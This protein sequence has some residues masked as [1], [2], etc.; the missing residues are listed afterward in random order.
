MSIPKGFSSWSAVLPKKGLADKSLTPTLSTAESLPNAAAVL[1]K[2]SADAVRAELQVLLAEIKRLSIQQERLKAEV[3]GM[4]TWKAKDAAANYNPNKNKS[5]P[6]LGGFTMAE[7]LGPALTLPVGRQNTASSSDWSEAAVETPIRN[8]VSGGYTSFTV[9]RDLL[10]MDL[11]PAN[12]DSDHGSATGE[13]QAPAALALPAG[14]TPDQL[15]RARKHR[16]KY[17]L[18]L[19]RPNSPKPKK[20]SSQKNSRLGI[21]ISRAREILGMTT[22]HTAEAQKRSLQKL[23]TQK[24]HSF[25]GGVPPDR[26][27]DIFADASPAGKQYVARRF[28]D[29]ISRHESPKQATEKLARQPV[30]VSAAV[31]T[32][33]A[34]PGRPCASSG[35]H[36]VH[37]DRQ[38]QQKLADKLI[39]HAVYSEVGQQEAEVCHT[40]LSQTHKGTDTPEKTCAPTTAA[41]TELD[42]HASAKHEESAALVASCIGT[43]GNSQQVRKECEAP[44]ADERQLPVGTAAEVMSACAQTVKGQEEMEG[45]VV[46]ALLA[47]LGA[48]QQAILSAVAAKQQPT[49]KAAANRQPIAGA[50]QTGPSSL[51]HVP[52]R[53]QTT[54]YLH[55]PLTTFTPAPSRIP[56]CSLTAFDCIEIFNTL[57]Y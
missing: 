56:P 32:N 2:P 28:D 22:T 53:R 40:G 23:I 51:V 9:A 44:V 13:S 38:P 11:S 39:S 34:A 19:S 16:R 43:S 57:E 3:N 25:N 1:E 31:S 48:Q 45:Q 29:V 33:A 35:L 27:D 10:R 5:A 21:T 17:G 54:R 18:A 55:L 20:L 37:E 24:S 30:A 7:C 46:F 42:S 12:E 41:L 52:N 26:F 4:H 6:K 47:S 49:Q 8:V 14:L 15:R 50:F 36:K